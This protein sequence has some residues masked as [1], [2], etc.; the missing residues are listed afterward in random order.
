M[1]LDFYSAL[2]AN[3]EVRRLE[4]EIIVCH[5]RGHLAPKNNN[6]EQYQTCQ[7][8]LKTLIRDLREAKQAYLLAKGDQNPLANILLKVDNEADFLANDLSWWKLRSQKF[9]TKKDLT[10]LI[11]KKARKFNLISIEVFFP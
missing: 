8:K 3:G 11:S 2:I 10:H 9:S 5:F 4:G 1:T 7:D 6:F